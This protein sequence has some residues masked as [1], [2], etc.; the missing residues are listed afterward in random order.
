MANQPIGQK[1]RPWQ[2]C[3]SVKNGEASAAITVGSPVILSMNGAD[4]GFSVVL[5][6]TAGANKS[7]ALFMGIACNPQTWAA[8]SYNDIICGGFVSTARVTAVTRSATSAAWVSYAAIG[9]GD[10]GSVD[11]VNNAIAWSA[12]AVAGAIPDICFLDSLASA[13]TISSTVSS[14][15]WTNSVNSAFTILNLPSAATVATISVRLFLHNL[16]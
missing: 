7:N 8:G 11:T 6:G 2:S 4:D 1:N 12:T 10:V 13:T 5:P 9:V 16:G 15:T 3:L 14:V